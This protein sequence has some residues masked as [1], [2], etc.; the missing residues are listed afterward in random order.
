MAALK[1]ARS[2]Y[3]QA[4][5]R[6]A[7][8]H[9]RFDTLQ[10]ELGK[11]VNDLE[12][13]RVELQDRLDNAARVVGKPAP[14]I[15]SIVGDNVDVGDYA[16]ERP[17][18]D[19]KADVPI[20]R[21]SY[22]YA[23]SSGWWGRWGAVQARASLHR[24]LAMERGVRHAARMVSDEERRVYEARRDME[25][26]VRKATANA[27]LGIKAAKVSLS[28]AHFISAAAR[29]AKRYVLSA[30]NTADG[31]ATAE[32]EAITAEQGAKKGQYGA[33][34]AEE[35]A[36]SAEQRAQA[37][38]EATVGQADAVLS[39][40]RADEVAASRVVPHTA[41][42]Y[43]GAARGAYYPYAAGYQGFAGG[44]Y[45]GGYAP[46]G[47]GI[48]PPPVTYETMMPPAAGAAPVALDG[49]ASPLSEAKDLIDKV[50]VLMQDLGEQLFSSPEDC[51]KTTAALADYSKSMET[52][53]SQGVAVAAR[54]SGADMGLVEKY[55]EVQ[56][57]S[58]AGRLEESIAA[59]QKAC[60]DKIKTPDAP[61][62]GA[63]G[64]VPSPLTPYF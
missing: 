42:P 10:K 30:V 31:A 46:Q 58:F 54:L 8:L 45:A 27:R 9:A 64:A 44:Y 18:S 23:D 28:G 63:A 51:G 13:S 55:A 24:T 62:G 16:E 7:S 61:F 22:N 43:A 5:G 47:Y 1:L 41:A 49:S 21:R 33:R 29:V 60:G 11:D 19:D 48:P 6:V 57:S 38:L 4:K 53:H 50:V 2:K 40:I 26:V 32:Q 20:R 25:E 17:S 14:V 52:F 15:P 36:K 3:E 37:V 35:G 39:R 59:A 12:A 34:I 56:V